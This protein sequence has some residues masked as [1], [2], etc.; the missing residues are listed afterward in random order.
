MDIFALF[1]FDVLILIKYPS[2]TPTQFESAPSLRM[3]KK[4]VSFFHSLIVFGDVI[5]SLS[6]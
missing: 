6:H 1:S 5:S 3:P 2:I 4:A